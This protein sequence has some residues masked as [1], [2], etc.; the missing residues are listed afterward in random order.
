MLL[1][2]LSS[3]SSL[4]FPLCLLRPVI[5]TYCPTLTV[6]N[7]LVATTRTVGSTSNRTCFQGFLAIGAAYVCSQHNATVGRWVGS[8]RC[9][10][11][12]QFAREEEPIPGLCPSLTSFCMSSILVC[13]CVSLTLYL[14]SYA[15]L[16]CNQR[17]FARMHAR[18]FSN[19]QAWCEPN[20]CIV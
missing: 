12:S 19:S 3:P 15:F 20:A 8:L 10:R 14:S 2:S 18:F 1:L 9:D 13:L 17:P 16:S 7:S 6:S 5:T 4:L 11:K